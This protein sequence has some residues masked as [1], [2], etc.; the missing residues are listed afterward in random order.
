LIPNRRHI[1]MAVAFLP[2]PIELT[3]PVP[4]QIAVR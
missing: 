3:A 1:G 4:D 2:I